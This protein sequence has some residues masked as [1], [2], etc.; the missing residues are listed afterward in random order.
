MFLHALHPLSTFLNRN[1]SP[2]HHVISNT[3]NGNVS[4]KY[5]CNDCIVCGNFGGLVE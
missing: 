5:M 4:L 2:C 1:V 3:A